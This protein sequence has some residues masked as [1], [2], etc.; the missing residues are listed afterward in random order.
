[1][2]DIDQYRDMMVGIVSILFIVSMLVISLIPI[3][4]M[5][6]INRYRNVARGIVA[7]LFISAG[8]VIGAMYA[9]LH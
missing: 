2:D 8:L 4:I 7:I 3:K 1:M 9:V 6:D 5:G